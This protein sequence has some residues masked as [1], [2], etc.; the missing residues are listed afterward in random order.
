MAMDIF[1]SVGRTYTKK[2]EVFVK[3]LES[4]LRDNKLNPVMVGRN[5]FAAENVLG[6][7]RAEMKKCSGTVIIA[8]ERLRVDAGTEFPGAEPL[9]D[10]PHDSMEPLPAAGRQITTPWNQIEASMAYTL[11]HPLLVVVEKGTHAEGLL[12]ER[13]GWFVQRVALEPAAFTTTQFKGVFLDW[14][15]RLKA[16]R[17]ETSLLD[18][19]HM[20]VWQLLGR[21][22]VP[23][24]WATGAAL[25]GLLMATA[26]AGY[27]VRDFMVKLQVPQVAQEH[28]DGGKG[29]ALGGPAIHKAGAAAKDS[30]P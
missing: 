20:G 15:E 18:P 14:L 10:A 8:F 19:A 6:T 30:G 16:P 22:S 21:L 25:V 13:N 3:A 27:Y 26:G 2:Q 5:R 23:S 28:A 1:V 17:D 9:V 29:S 7:I 4:F 11:G 12:E 24:L